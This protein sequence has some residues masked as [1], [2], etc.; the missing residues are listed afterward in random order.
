MLARISRTVLVA[1]ASLVCLPLATG[2]QHR[3]GAT[4]LPDRFTAVAIS[5][6]GPRST[7]LTETLELTIE[8][9]ST[10]AER[11]RLVESDG[12]RAG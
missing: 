8:R 7:P 2:G 5:A 4:G 6:G 10:E 12:Q 9:W 1:I 3:P 11:R